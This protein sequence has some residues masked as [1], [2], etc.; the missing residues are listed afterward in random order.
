MNRLKD[1]LEV[2]EKIK[3]I[4]IHENK[5]NDEIDKNIQKL[6]KSIF[7]LEGLIQQ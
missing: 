5:K 4:Q 6:R 2:F 3:F 1:E 7:E